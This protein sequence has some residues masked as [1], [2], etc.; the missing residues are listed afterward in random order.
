MIEL[1]FT[2]AFSKMTKMTGHMSLVEWEM[3]MQMQL[4]LSQQLRR[5]TAVKA[6]FSKGFRSYTYHEFWNSTSTR[7]RTG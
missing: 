3:Y 5:E 2:G 1:T 6:C 7:K 4:V